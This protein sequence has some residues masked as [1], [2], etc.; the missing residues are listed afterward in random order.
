MT[1]NPVAIPAHLLNPM[2]PLRKSLT[3]T[4]QGYLPFKPPKEKKKEESKPRCEA[5]AC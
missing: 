1:A 4:T 3:V 2:P 5:G